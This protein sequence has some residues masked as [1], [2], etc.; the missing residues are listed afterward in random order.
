M[1]VGGWLTENF[2]LDGSVRGIVVLIAGSAGVQ[3]LVA[4]SLYIINGEGSIV[5]ALSHVSGKTHAILLPDDTVD[6]VA[7]HRTLDGEYF[8]SNGRDARHWPDVGHP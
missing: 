6:W 1:C 5:D 3:A 2:H 8:T 7:G 4:S